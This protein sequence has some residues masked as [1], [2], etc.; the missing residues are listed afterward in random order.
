M[1]ALS[2]TSR[3]QRVSLLAALTM[4]CTPDE[5]LPQRFRYEIHERANAR[6]LDHSV[7]V[8]GKKIDLIAPER[9]ETLDNR[10]VSQFRSRSQLALR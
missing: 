10:A 3:F 2:L 8:N 7:R 5:S 9:L 4:L 6:G 1:S